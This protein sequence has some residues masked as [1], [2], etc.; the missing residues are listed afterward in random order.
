MKLH[1][2]VNN[3]PTK[4]A[5]TSPAKIGERFGLNNYSR[6]YHELRGEVPGTDAGDQ[7]KV[8]F[9]SGKARTASFTY[10]VVEDDP[11]D[12]LIVAAEDYSGL[13]SSSDY[14][15]STAPN[16]LG[17]YED[18]LTAAGRT[19]DVYD[20]DARGRTAPD[21]LG[22]LSHYDAVVYYT[23]NDL[24]TREA[25]QIPGDASRLANDE[26]LELRSYL[27]EGGKLLYGGQN[28]GYEY[29]FAYPFDPVDNGSCNGKDDEVALAASSSPTTSSS[30]T[31][32]RA[33]TTTMPAPS[34][35]PKRRPARHWT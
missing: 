33:S 34:V 35:G 1:F 30:T 13:S 10:T 28:A 19:Y 18:A 5:K 16:Y 32:A 11:A 26:M 27:N 24:I 15:S 17:Y 20:V 6:Y 31:S 23:G 8:W 22:V 2:Q 25:D 12:V 3:G 29:S 14:P 7:V 4:T 21:D 9:T